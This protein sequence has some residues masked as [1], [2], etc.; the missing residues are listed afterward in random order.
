MIAGVALEID[1]LGKIGCFDGVT[2]FSCAGR[3]L[4]TAGLVIEDS[5]RVATLRAFLEEFLV[6]FR[7][8]SAVMHLKQVEEPSM[9]ESY[10]QMEA[11]RSLRARGASEI[12]GSKRA[13]QYLLHFQGLASAKLRIDLN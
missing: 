2:I 5:D 8:V 1:R 13:V 3:G 12:M 10:T 11:D 7:R 4:R 9:L 6:K